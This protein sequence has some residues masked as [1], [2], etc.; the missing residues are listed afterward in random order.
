MTRMSA[1]DY[2]LDDDP[3]RVD[4]DA[5]VAFLTTEAYW[6]RWRGPQDIKDQIAAAWRVVGVYD[7]TGATAGTPTCPTCTCCPSTAAPGWARPS[8]G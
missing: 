5:A 1:G 4:A 2:E 6:G 8:C 7:R 3:S